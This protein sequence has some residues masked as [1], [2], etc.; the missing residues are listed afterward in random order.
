MRAPCA[1]L[2]AAAAHCVRAAWRLA[3]GHAPK[4]NWLAQVP[5]CQA[6]ANDGAR[7]GR[8]YSHQNQL[9]R[10][11]CVQHAELSWA[12]LAR[13]AVA[14]CTFAGSL[15]KMPPPARPR[16][17]SACQSPRHLPRPPNDYT[18]AIVQRAGQQSVQRSAQRGACIVHQ[19]QHRNQWHA[20]IVQAR[21]VRAVHSPRC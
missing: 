10:V 6:A 19:Q 15:P 9:L 16:A 4:I 1:R 7:A 12:I 8:S 11:G 2:A 14:F 13:R 21:R 17:A 3:V 20:R 18:L 5:A